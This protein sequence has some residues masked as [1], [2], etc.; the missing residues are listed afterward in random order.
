[1]LSRDGAI[2]DYTQTLYRSCGVWIHGRPNGLP[3]H[4]A[5]FAEIFCSHAQLTAVKD[6]PATIQAEHF[7]IFRNKS[8]PQD[9]KR[10]IFSHHLRRQFNPVLFKAGRIHAK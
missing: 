1:M 7:G 6:Q 3:P 4:L 8:E 5:M 10:A 2:A 9:E